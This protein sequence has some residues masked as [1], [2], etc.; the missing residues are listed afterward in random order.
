MSENNIDDF[1]IFATSKRIKKE[2][3]GPYKSPL[4]TNSKWGIQEDR[5]IEKSAEKQAEAPRYSAPEVQAVRAASYH[6]EA[7]SSPAQRATPQAQ[8]TYEDVGNVGSELQKF[9]KYPQKTYDKLMNKMVLFN[10]EE[11]FLVRDLASEI[12]M[13][14]K[15]SSMPNKGSLPRITENTVI[16]AALKAVFSKIGRTNTDLTTLQTEEAL[17]SYFNSLLK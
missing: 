11:Y 16:R 2:E 17:E 6:Q 14:R 13:A 15:R 4:D 12:S 7:V 10:E 9:R 1:S 5:P 8:N 3:P